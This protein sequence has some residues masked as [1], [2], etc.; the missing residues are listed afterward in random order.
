M[1]ERGV[2]FGD[3][4]RLR[5]LEPRRDAIHDVEVA[6][7][8][9]AGIDARV[10]GAR[11]RAG[12]R[13]FPDVAEVEDALAVRQQRVREVDLPVAKHVAV[14]EAL[15][16]RMLPG[17]EKVHEPGRREDPVFESLV[18]VAVGAQQLA[19]AMM[20]RAGERGPLLRILRLAHQ[21]EGGD[22]QAR[23]GDEIVIL[24]EVE[25]PSGPSARTHRTQDRRGARAIARM[26]ARSAAVKSL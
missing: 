17:V 4:L 7:Q 25:L 8:R 12:Q 5:I 2:T 23:G 19:G 18:V 6:L 3:R 20:M 13:A 22:G 16:G 21:G 9:A 10:F 1:T 15:A 26:R 11:L 14:P 24:R